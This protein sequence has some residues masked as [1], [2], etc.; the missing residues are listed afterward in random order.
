MKN[1]VKVCVGNN[2][3]GI[4]GAGITDA[5]GIAVGWTIGAVWAICVCCVDDI[6]V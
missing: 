6:G 2:E 1:V 4:T 5:G 3:A